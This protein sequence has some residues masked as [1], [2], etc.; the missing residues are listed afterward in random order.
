MKKLLFIT[1]SVSYGYG[2]EKSLADVLN[3]FDNT[4]YDISI[5]PLFKYSNNSIFNNNIKVLEPIIDYTDK[6]LDEVKALKNYYNLLSNPSLF[7]K[8]LRKKI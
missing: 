5:L 8:W 1:W 3:R 4:K 6:N 2:T 7:N